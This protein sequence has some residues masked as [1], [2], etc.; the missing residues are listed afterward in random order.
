MP[1]K[2]LRFTAVE[3]GG[4]RQISFPLHD[5][6]VNASHVGALLE[7]LLD[8]ITKEIQATQDV[9]DGDVLQAVCMALAI[10][11]N[12]VEAP[13]GAVRAMVAS[14]LQQADE[15]VSDSV[16]QPAGRA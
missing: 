15:A 9:S 5:H 3:P 11:M 14:T 10:R 12:L 8:S 1:S 13:P 6:T 2:V 16:V 4:A 7:A